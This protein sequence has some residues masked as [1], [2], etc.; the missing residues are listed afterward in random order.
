MN[1]CMY[2]VFSDAVVVDAADTLIFGDLIIIRCSDNIL[3][4]DQMY[5]VAPRAIDLHGIR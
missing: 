3:I 2:V 5:F 4:S 1:V